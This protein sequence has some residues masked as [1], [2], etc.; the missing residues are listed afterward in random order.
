MTV[1]RSALPQRLPRPPTVSCTWRVPA[2]TAASVLA[3]ASRRR[4]A[5]GCRAGCAVAGPSFRFHFAKTIRGA[6][7]LPGA[8]PAGRG[9]R[10]SPPASLRGFF[11]ESKAARKQ[12]RLGCSWHDCRPEVL[13]DF[14]FAQFYRMVAPQQSYRSRAA[15]MVRSDFTSLYDDL[16]EE[17]VNGTF[18]WPNEETHRR[19]Q[20]R[21]V[22]EGMPH[23]YEI[24]G[25]PGDEMHLVSPGKQPQLEGAQPAPPTARPKRRPPG[26][27]TALACGPSPSTQP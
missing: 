13:Y 12:R 21:Q 2:R 11:H 8:F 27:I 16:A 15:L 18:H 25:G 26:S 24:K 10:S 14:A 1:H 6:R 3:T 7:C 5:C 17:S 23:L 4:C 9:T 22:E 19:G 20:N